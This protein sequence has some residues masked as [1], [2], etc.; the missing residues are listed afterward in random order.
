M[1]RV[2]ILYFMLLII[3]GLRLLGFSFISSP[4]EA[5]Q[6]E[7]LALVEFFG[8]I[9]DGVRV[10]IE[11]D[12]VGFDDEVY[13]LSSDYMLQPQGSFVLDKSSLIID[14]IGT[15]A[16]GTLFSSLQTRELDFISSSNEGWH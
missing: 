16:R 11:R 15:E 2:F 4:V 10:Y 7:G 5:I 3:L 14:L 9:P 1:R 13:A 6:R 12:R 8:S